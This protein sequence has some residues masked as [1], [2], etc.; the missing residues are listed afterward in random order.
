[1]L[2]PTVY[3]PSALA[4]ALQRRES[5][6]RPQPRAT[7]RDVALDRSSDRDSEPSVEFCAAGSS[8]V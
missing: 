5:S 3:L 4:A 6:D 2:K 8:A 7:G 1:M